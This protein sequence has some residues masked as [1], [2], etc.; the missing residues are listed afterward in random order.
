MA[1]KKLRNYT[2][3][4]LETR[5]MGQAV[6]DMMST[7]RDSR[8]NFERR[9][10]DNNFF[11]DGHHFRYLSRTQ[12]KIVDLSERANINDPMR[13]IPKASRQVRGLANLLVS[14]DPVPVVFPEPINTAAYAEDP[15]ALLLAK[16]EAK[17]VAKLTGHW[18]TEEFK[19][20]DLTEKTAL[21]VLLAAKHGISY[22]QVWP[23]AVKEKIRTQVYDAF[24]IFLMGSLTELEDQPFVIKGI[25]KSIAEIKANE[26]FDE[27]QLAK[28]HPDNRNASSEI[29]EAY[30]NSRHGGQNKND[31]AATVILKEAFI[32]EYLTKENAS[33]IKKQE[34]GGNILASREEG[35]PIIRHVFVAGD[36][37]LRDEYVNL[38]SYPFV[39]FRFEPGPMYQVAP[40]ERFIPLNKSLDVVLSRLERYSN[41]MVVGTWLKRQ[42]EQLNLSNVA[43]G[44]VIEYKG[45]PP[46]QG[47]IAPIPNFFFNYIELLQSFIEEQGVTTSTL[48]KIP[49]GVKAN[50]AIESLKESEFANL[51]ISRRRLDNALKKIAQKFLDIADQNFVTPQTSM[52]LERGEPNF[53]DIMGKSAISKREELKIGI[54]ANVVPISK[55]YKV[56]IEVQSGVAYTRGGRKDAMTRLIQELREYAVEGYV[57]PQAVKVAIEKYLEAFNFG[58]TNEFMEEFDKY[59]GQGN[60]SDQQKDAIKLAMAEVFQDLQGTDAIP[61]EKTRVEESKLGAAQAISDIDKARQ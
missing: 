19:N 18:L 47:N 10:Y 52:F 8:H 5:Q 51:V 58:A 15:Q 56:E 20:Q 37:W 41:T 43:G 32:K 50:A 60:L 16:Q 54:S 26:L 27:D 12:N 55:E 30:M 59:Q 34:N 31:Q 48:G 28:L 49:K 22:M 44:Q 23:D 53:F 24:D 9:W 1:A 38:T 2:T 39:D 33:R 29:K 57:P 42:G 4:K 11:D 36:V 7:A 45:S 6:D 21:M 13:A 35:D 14:T 61:D 3:D 25:K 17:R 46:V 40:I